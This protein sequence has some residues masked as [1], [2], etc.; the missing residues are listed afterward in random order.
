VSVE[1]CASNVLRKTSERAR[2]TDDVSAPSAIMDVAND[3]DSPSR[4]MAATGGDVRAHSSEATR[5]V[6]YA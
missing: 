3:D 5:G 1:T 4:G 2:R 6:G